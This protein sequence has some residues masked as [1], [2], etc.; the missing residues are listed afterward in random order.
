MRRKRARRGSAFSELQLIRLSELNV[1]ATAR[2]VSF[3]GGR[4]FRERM[5]GMGLFPGIDIKLVQTGGSGGMM[6][7]SVGGSRIMVCSRNA[8]RILL[9]KMS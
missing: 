5:N 7:I 3:H 8:G 2:I 9:R 1:G 6:L 4:G